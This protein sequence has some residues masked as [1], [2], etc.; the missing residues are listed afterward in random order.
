MVP[1]HIV[2]EVGKRL[3]RCGQPTR[4]KRIHAAEDELGCLSERHTQTR[5][6]TEIDQRQDLP[7]LILTLREQP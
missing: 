6:P 2:N 7:L 1:A 4:D 3:C 5:D